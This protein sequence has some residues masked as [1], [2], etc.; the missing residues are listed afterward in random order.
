MSQVL[1]HGIQ[2]QGTANPGSIS[3][4][5]VLKVFSQVVWKTA[6]LA[7]SNSQTSKCLPGP[8]NG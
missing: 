7:A 2:E 8:G 5:P 3:H 1:L 6:A 4:Q